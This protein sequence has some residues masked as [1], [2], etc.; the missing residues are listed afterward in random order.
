[1]AKE[2]V[3]WVVSGRVQGVGFRHHTVRI[4]RHFGVRGW[5]RN[6]MDGTVLIHVAGDAKS[7]AGFREAVRKGPVFGHVDHIAET[8]LDAGLLQGITGFQV[9]YA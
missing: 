2:C 4:A 9:T 7:L 8:P 1:M 3:A 6:Q 5:I